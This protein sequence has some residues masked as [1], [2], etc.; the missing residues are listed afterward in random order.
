MLALSKRLLRPKPWRLSDLDEVGKGLEP[1]RSLFDLFQ[2]TAFRVSSR[3]GSQIR[4]CRGFAVDTRQPW[5]LSRRGG[6][7]VSRR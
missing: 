1:S 3:G 6:W 2:V 5:P 7:F 4:P